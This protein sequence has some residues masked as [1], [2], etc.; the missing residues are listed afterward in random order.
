MDCIDPDAGTGTFAGAVADTGALLLPD[1]ACNAAIAAATPASDATA[2]TCTTT[3][4]EADFFLSHEPVV[5]SGDE[6]GAP[7]FGEAGATVSSFLVRGVE[8]TAASAATAFAF[9]LRGAR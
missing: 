3:D 6:A 9:V 8:D 7:P 5:E 4:D 1:V 2:G